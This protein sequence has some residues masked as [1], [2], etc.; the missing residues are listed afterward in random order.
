[1]SHTMDPTATDVNQ[2]ELAQQLLVPA[3][4]QGADLVGLMGC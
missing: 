1:M 2:Q 3:R 4:E